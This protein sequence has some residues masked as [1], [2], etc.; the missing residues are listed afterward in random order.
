MK[1][2]GHIDEF[3]PVMG[4][5]LS[6]RDERLLDRYGRAIEP[7][8]CT[9]CGACEP[10]CPNGVRISTVNRALMYAEGYGEPLLAR[11]TFREAAAASGCAG[12]ATCVARCANGLNIA[13]KMERA[14]GLLA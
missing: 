3:M 8:Y 11:E 14:R 2:L 4:M 9:L 10:T 5:K 6:A 7:F 12:C 1:T 13:E